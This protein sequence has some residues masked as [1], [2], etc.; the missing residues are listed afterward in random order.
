MSKIKLIFNGEQPSGVLGYG[1]LNPGEIFSV[2]EKDSE[3]ILEN[4][5]VK[6]ILTEKS[7]VKVEKVEAENE[8]IQ[9][10]KKVKK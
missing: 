10:V 1:L 8:T 4:P 5:L 2:E 9:E 6:R 3:R 7:E